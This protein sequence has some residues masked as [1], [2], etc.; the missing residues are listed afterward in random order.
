ML[1]GE[2]VEGHRQRVEGW[3]SSP[4]AR[5]V[6]SVDDAL[7]TW[8][9]GL[10]IFVNQ[11]DGDWD[12]V[13]CLVVPDAEDEDQRHRRMHGRDARNEDGVP[14]A[15]MDEELPALYACGV[16]QHCRRHVH[17]AQCST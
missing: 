14:S 8:S 1:E 16:C 17:V 13:Q 6:A 15:T 12:I 4:H 2:H 9:E 11:L 3:G 7:D 10:V 5:R